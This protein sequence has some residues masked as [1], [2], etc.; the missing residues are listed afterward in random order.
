MKK[1]TKG[2][3]RYKAIR[4]AYRQVFKPKRRDSNEK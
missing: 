1:E 2:R 3:Q 4:R